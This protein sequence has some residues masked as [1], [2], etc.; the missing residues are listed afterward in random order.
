MRMVRR[1]EIAFD[2][3]TLEEWMTSSKIPMSSQQALHSA[4]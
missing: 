1:I 3:S 4:L 2:A